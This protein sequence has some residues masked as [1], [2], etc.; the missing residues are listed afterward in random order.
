MT[1]ALAL[2]LA[3]AVSLPVAAQQV[4]DPMSTDA[5]NARLPAAADNLGLNVNI[6]HFGAHG[7]G[8]NHPATAEQQAACP[9]TPAPVSSDTC[10]LQ[11]AI[12]HLK[13]KATYPQSTQVAATG[14]TVFVPSGQ[15]QMDRAIV[16]NDVSVL[17]QGDGV[18]ASRLTWAAGVNGF[19]WNQTAHRS[20]VNT[21]TVIAGGTGYA[22]GNLLTIVGGTCVTQPVLAATVAAG[23]VTGFTISNPG[24]C[25]VIPPNEATP[26]TGGSGSGATARMSS[27]QGGGFNLIGGTNFQITANTLNTLAPRPND[28]YFIKSSGIAGII[29]L[30]TMGDAG[31]VPV[32][33]F[34]HLDVGSSAWVR[35]GG[36]SIGGGVNNQVV[37]LGTSTLGAPQIASTLQATGLPT[38]AG[39]GG[40][41]VC[42]DTAG[43][44]YKKA[45]CP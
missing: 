34:L 23:V 42:I 44:M 28:V 39:A 22:N 13:S 10:A 31:N 18:T 8:V 5:S 30:N 35:L 36:D 45:A 20:L 24:D 2:L 33:T 43:V 26:L 25:S 17:F 37:N 38:S 3:L 4:P 15:Y 40:L 11:A 19:E 12:N 41:A 29:G 6:R 16:G 27:S 7:D 14:G 21:P 32:T 9:E 1:R